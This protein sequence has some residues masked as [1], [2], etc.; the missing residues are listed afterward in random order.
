MRNHISTLAVLAFACTL[1]APCA[2]FAQYYSVCGTAYYYDYREK[3]DNSTTLLK[4][5]DKGTNR[6]ARR[7][8]VYLMDE[9]GVYN[10]YTEAF[11]GDDDV[12]GSTYTDA[13]TGAFCFHNVGGAEDIYVLTKY[14]SDDTEV[15]TDTGTVYTA[16]P[17]V[18][19]NFG[20]NIYDYNFSISC[21]DETDGTCDSSYQAT[22]TYAL[23]NRVANILQTGVDVDILVADS[24]YHRNGNNGPV[25]LYYRWNSSGWCNSGS[26]SS[27]C[28]D[29][30]IDGADWNNPYIPAHEIGHALWKRALGNCNASGDCGGMHCWDPQ[31]CA[32][33]Y[34]VS[35]KCA[36]SEGWADFVATATYW[37]QGQSG[38]W[39]KTNSN[40]NL[41]GQTTIGNPLFSNTTDEDCVNENQY[42]HL[43]EANVARYFWDLYD[44][45]AVDEKYTEALSK[46]FATLLSVWDAFP[47]GYGDGDVMET[48]SDGRNAWDYSNNAY[49]IIGSNSSIL[50]N[51]CIGNQDH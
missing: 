26:Y 2:L 24:D 5:T 45:T 13:S 9:D 47:S 23:Q 49:S 33:N 30:C 31:D 50:Y 48:G 7:T 40:R 17:R 32:P 15:K 6:P 16:S 20:R 4:A 41:E 10:D 22:V 25:E 38:A 46:N 14:E 21:P 8:K 42:P 19:V 44:S 51:N 39:Y 43:L 35:E 29:I 37:G 1:L 28:N 12:L 27:G 18:E 3:R 11:E 34:W 36:T